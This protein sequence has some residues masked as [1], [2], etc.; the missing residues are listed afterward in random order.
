MVPSL[1]WSRLSCAA[2]IDYVKVWHEGPV[3]VRLGRK[4]KW[5][6]IDGSSRWYSLTV[7]EPTLG[8]IQYVVEALKNPSLAEVEI[9]V[10]IWPPGDLLGPERSEFLQSAYVA[11]AAR[12]RPE[13][14]AKW[15]YGLR[16]S[17]TC[18][19]MKP[20]PFH[21]RLPSPD[22]QLIYGHRGEWHQSKLYY[23]RTDCKRALPAFEHRVRLE[24]ALRRGA[25]EAFGLDRLDSLIGYPYRSK[26]A[27]HF[28]F[29]AGARL[30]GAS[31]LT[32]RTA[33][34]KQGKIERR[35][36]K[37]G[38]G[39]FAISLNLPPQ[40]GLLSAKMIKRR[41]RQ[42]IPH[43][44]AVLVRDQISN[45]KIGEALKTLQ[46]RMACRIIRAGGVKSSAASC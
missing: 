42:Q 27:K 5:N 2:S 28:R 37:A 34:K 15:G 20:E 16:G 10:D 6:R 12:F 25:M 14:A 43:R 38:A 21:Q 8:E 36:T 4:A 30:R 44:D 1:D 23:K 3:D 29:V 11:C 13:D 19:G 41:A 40:T 45:G 32:L 18:S 39:G 17:V 35:W 7:Q 33:K 22:E 24:L 9:S 31:R 46:R 26:L